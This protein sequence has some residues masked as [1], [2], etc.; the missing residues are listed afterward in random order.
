MTRRPRCLP[1]VTGILADSELLRSGLLARYSFRIARHLE[2]MRSGCVRLVGSVSPC[3]RHPAASCRSPDMPEMLKAV[4][5]PLAEAPTHIS[6]EDYLNAMA[7]RGASYFRR[8]P[9]SWLFQPPLGPMKHDAGLLLRQRWTVQK[10]RRAP[11]FA[12]QTSARVPE[13]IF[14]FQRK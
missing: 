4:S 9:K 6:K 12:V 10:R 1:I 2:P 8:K 7:A 3:R 14:E 5:P 11:R 13:S